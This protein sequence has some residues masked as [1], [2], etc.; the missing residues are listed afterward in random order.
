[1]TDIPG[2]ADKVPLET[3]LKQDKIIEIDEDG[4]VHLPQ[5]G[6]AQPVDPGWL[7]DLI[8]EC[9]KELLG[10]GVEVLV[11]EYA[12]E[13]ARKLAPR[14]AHPEPAVPE[15]PQW[16]GLARM[17]YDSLTCQHGGCF[18]CGRSVGHEGDCQWLNTE[19]GKE[20]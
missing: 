17:M 9:N 19:A 8:H 12:D 13:L 11:A 16:E 5:E 6:A 20:T 3:V 1:M 2:G 15:G 7:C 10:R 4:K 14:L 18:F